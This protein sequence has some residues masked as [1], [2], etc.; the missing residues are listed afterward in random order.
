MMVNL[1]PPH[2]QV[3]HGLRIMTCNQY[4][5]L[6]VLQLNQSSRN[7]EYC[8]SYLQNQTPRLAVS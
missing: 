1:G 6:S 7:Q 3:I 8:Y 4:V 2:E 5:V